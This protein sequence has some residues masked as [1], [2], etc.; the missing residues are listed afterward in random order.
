MADYYY[1]NSSIV[2]PAYG[3]ESY[4]NSFVKQG[5]TLSSVKQEQNYNTSY[6]DSS[7]QENC[8]SYMKQE[9]DLPQDNTYSQDNVYSQDADYSQDNPY[10]QNNTYS[11]GGGQAYESSYSRYNKRSYNNDPQPNYGGD[12]GPAKR[13]RRQQPSEGIEMRCLVPSRAAGGIIGRGGSNIRDLRDSLQI[14][15]FL[16]DATAP[17]RVLKVKGSPQKCGEVI[18]KV[19]PQ[20]EEVTNSNKQHQ[21]DD[22]QQEEKSDS[23]IKLLVHQSQAGGII[24]TKGVKIKE[25][26][27]QTGAMIK[28][29]Q[30]CAGMSTD[31]IVIVC[32]T[33][34]VISS[35]VVLIMELLETIPPKGPVEEYDPQL[36]ADY[37]YEEDYYEDNYYEYE[38]DYGYD[39]DFFGYEDDY[40]GFDD[41]YGYGF[42]DGYG[43]G[44]GGSDFGGYRGGFYGRGGPP[45][46]R[47]GFRGPPRGMGFRGGRGH[48]NNR[49][50]G[51]GRRGR[52][53][54]AHEYGNY[55]YY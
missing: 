50:R 21:D 31:R 20:I 12:G 45:R 5:E 17:E 13:M 9:Q 32:G 22:K 28:V 24:G 2:N 29:H 51:F 34:A 4:K 35:C 18:L 49:G 38:D 19:L 39:D 46:G 48:F 14:Q 33:H 37:A 11:Q 15:V 30:D 42:D 43:Y 6:N 53:M 40:Y 1:G 47:G 44:G 36:E 54:P 25:L 8:T 52:G 55:E 7:Q 3:K 26:R 41:G 16:P 23:S 10:F 27:Q